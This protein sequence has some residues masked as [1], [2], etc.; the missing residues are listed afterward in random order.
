MRRAMSALLFLIPLSSLF[1]A[2]VAAQQRRF[3]I[4]PFAGYRLSG[5]VDSSSRLGFDFDQDVEIDE[6][7]I[8]GVI[9]DIPLTPNWQLELLANR[10]QTTFSVDEGL[11][12]PTEELGDVDLSYFHA[13]FLYQWGGGQVSPFIVGTLGLARIEPDFPELDGENYFSGSLGG[14]VKIFLSENIGL[15]LEGRGFWTDI[16]TDFEERY[17]RY[18]ADGAITQGEASAG[19]II[20]F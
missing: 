20:A 9:F 5:E 15:R 2:A 6:S 18:D 10:Q 7:A 19:L 4:T 11:F 8:Y 13:G 16:E 14:G 1:P 3:E 12:S 17:D